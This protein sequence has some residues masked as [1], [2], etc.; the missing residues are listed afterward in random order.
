M[1]N[2]RTDR[3]I[4]SA[5]ILIFLLMTACASLSNSRELQEHAADARKASQPSNVIPLRRGYYVASDTPCGLASNATLL[6]LRSNGLG[7]SR[8]FCEFKDIQ[9]MS[10]AVYLVEEVCTDFQNEGHET[11][12]LQY[13]LKSSERFVSKDQNGAVHDARYC[14]QS[15]LPPDWRGTDIRPEVE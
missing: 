6:L 15:E 13:T 9:Q 5:I 10:S 12:R 11:H 3:R 8:Y 7:G 14:A 1:C 4:P 2:D